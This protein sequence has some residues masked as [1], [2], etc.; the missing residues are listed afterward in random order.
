M[1]WL[2]EDGEYIEA[3]RA[4]AQLEVDSFDGLQTKQLIAP[5]S[6]KIHINEVYI[7][8]T[9]K[10]GQTIA[11]IDRDDRRIEAVTPKKLRTIM[12]VIMALSPEEQKFLMDLFADMKSLVVTRDYFDKQVND[13][14][15]NFDKQVN[16]L[17]K[18]VNDLRKNIGNDVSDVIRTELKS[19]IENL[20]KDLKLPPNP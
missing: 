16:D 2:I 9:I 13:L 6:G 3:G 8:V 17:S 14:R 19:H 1:E 10:N 18:Q 5:I 7:G 20:R 4:V 12:D 15:K 11:V